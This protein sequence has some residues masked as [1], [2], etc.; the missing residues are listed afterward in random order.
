MITEVDEKTANLIL[1]IRC[2]DDNIAPVIKL[3]IL[4]CKR[5][6]NDWVPRMTKLPRNCPKCKSPYW[7]KPRVL[8]RRP[9]VAFSRATL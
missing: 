2:T 1:D 3:P 9:T 7:N 4:K 6:G 5:C 8:N